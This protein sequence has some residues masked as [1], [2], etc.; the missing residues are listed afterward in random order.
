MAKF[1]TADW[2]NALNDKLNTDVQY[3]RIARNWEGDLLFVVEQ[4]GPLA[5]RIVF[6]LDLWHGKCRQAV[7]VDGGNE[8]RSA[9]ITLKSPY[10][11]FLKVLLG[12]WEPMQALMTGKLSVKGSMVLLMKNIPVVLDFVR[13]AREVTDAYL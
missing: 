12:E 8:A 9:A 11:N 3:A 7:I 13:C 6:Y 5:E 4:G 10:P 2:V 1:P